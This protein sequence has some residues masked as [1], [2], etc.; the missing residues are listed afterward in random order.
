MKSGDKV[1]T[2]RL[3]GDVQK[4]IEAIADRNHIAVTD[5][6]RLCLLHVLPII[7]KEGITIK[8]GKA[9]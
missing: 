2:V 6:I 9:S 3:S 4:K 8:P 1:N 5:V 7:E